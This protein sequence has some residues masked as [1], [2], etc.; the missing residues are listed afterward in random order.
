MSVLYRVL[1]IFTNNHPSSDSKP[2][3]GD[4]KLADRLA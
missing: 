4:I 1:V 2:S 3:E